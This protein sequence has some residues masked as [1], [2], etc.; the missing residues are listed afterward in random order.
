MNDV[1]QQRYLFTSAGGSINGISNS[2]CGG[3]NS[4]LTSSTH[5]LSNCSTATMSSSLLTNNP[6]KL[7]NSELSSFSTY[8]AGATSTSTN[9]SA[10]TTGITKNDKNN[11]T[12]NPLT[13]LFLKFS[14]NSNNNSNT[15]KSNETTITNQH[16]HPNN[17]IKSNSN[18]NHN[19]N[20]NNLQ[21]NQLSATI[22][23][24]G[25]FRG[26]N[27]SSSTQNLQFHSIAI[28]SNHHSTSDSATIDSLTQY[29]PPRVSGTIASDLNLVISSTSITLTPSTSP[30]PSS[31]LLSST[32]S[33]SSIVT[34]TSSSAPST[35]IN[36]PTVIGPT[37]TSQQQ[38]NPS[39][40]S[41]NNYNM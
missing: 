37:T 8:T 25:S 24:A 9:T 36:S 23:S 2:N 13:K 11:K 41:S 7:L 40:D 12:A 6:N 34:S 29:Q 35:V 10:T 5:T 31:T 14:S 21:H 28:P 19:N 15:N 16:H 30:K 33:S 32:S 20:I 26:H 18:V 17:L 3:S 1:P 22:P 27:L 38:S 39:W 4:L